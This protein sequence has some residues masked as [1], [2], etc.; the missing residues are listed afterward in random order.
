MGARSRARELLPTSERCDPSLVC[1]LGGK[2]AAASAAAA[3]LAPSGM[4]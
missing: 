1:M 4:V 3:P 2:E